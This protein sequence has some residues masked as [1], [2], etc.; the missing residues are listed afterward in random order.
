MIRTNKTLSRLAAVQILFQL[1]FNEKM[2]IEV[3][4]TIS[5]ELIYQKYISFKDINIKNYGKLKLDKKWFFILVNKVFSFK[6]EIDK[7]LIDYFDEGWTV[8]RM[9]TTLINILRCAYVEFNYFSKI[10][11]NVVISEYTNVSACFFNESEINFVN[12]FLDRLSK[13]YIK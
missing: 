13:L 9:D 6:K 8:D 10:P 5:E 12:S 7:N 11:L 1:D 4:K 3:L 2:N